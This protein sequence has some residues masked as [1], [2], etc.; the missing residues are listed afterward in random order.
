MRNELEMRAGDFGWIV[1]ADALCSD[2]TTL[3]DVTAALRFEAHETQARLAH[4]PLR[5]A[6]A[7]SIQLTLR[8]RPSQ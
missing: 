7:P 6:D 1:S 5:R 3:R 4:L 8:P 2:G